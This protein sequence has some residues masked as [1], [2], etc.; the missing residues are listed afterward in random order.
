MIQYHFKNKKGEKYESN[1]R[2]DKKAGRS[3]N[4]CYK[5]VRSHEVLQ[6][7]DQGRRRPGPEPQR[8]AE[9]RLRVRVNKNQ[10]SINPTCYPGPAQRAPGEERNMKAPSSKLQA[11]TFCR[12][13][14]CHIDRSSKRQAPATICHID[15]R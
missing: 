3:T 13:S 14:L 8:A 15:K 9:E 7:P 10:T 5:M 4:G 11:A 6:H 12:A 1:Y 2:V